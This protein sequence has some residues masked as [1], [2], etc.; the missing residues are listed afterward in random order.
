M[1]CATLRRWSHSVCA[2]LLASAPPTTN[3]PSALLHFPKANAL[4]SH[5]VCRLHFQQHQKFPTNL[6]LANRNMCFA[7]S[8]SKWEQ[9]QPQMWPHDT[10]SEARG[11][12]NLVSPLFCRLI[13]ALC[14]ILLCK[15]AF[16]VGLV[17][18]IEGTLEDELENFYYRSK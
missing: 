9:K 15:Y 6:W 8:Q 12:A 13:I 2:I 1:L 16:R 3:L 11:S 18:E 4:M 17:S 14:V 5:K 7:G 10:R